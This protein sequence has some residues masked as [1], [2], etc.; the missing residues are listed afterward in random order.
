MSHCAQCRSVE[1]RQTSVIPDAAWFVIPGACEG[2]GPES[3]LSTNT[4]TRPVPTRSAASIA[5]TTRAFSALASR[6]RSCTT[7]SRVPLRE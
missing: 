3:N 4:L 2:D 6:T 5:S 7:S 1:N